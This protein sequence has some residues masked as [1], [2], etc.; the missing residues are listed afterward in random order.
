[1]PWEL[2]MS[3]HHAGTLKIERVFSGQSKI[4]KWKREKW[5]FSTWTTDSKNMAWHKKS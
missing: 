3:C 2:Q 4:P 5:L 1:L